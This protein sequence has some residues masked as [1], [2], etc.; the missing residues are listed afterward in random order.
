MGVFIIGPIVVAQY[1]A[2]PPQS[3][4]IHVESFRY[5]KSPAVIYCTRGD[6]LHLTFSSRDTGHSFFLQEFDMDVKVNPN[7]TRVMQFRASDPSAIPETKHEVV[8]IAEHPGLL[9]YLVSK[10]NFRCHVWCGPLHAFEQ[11]SLIIGP[12]NLLL[13][14]LGL[15]LGIFIIGTNRRRRHE[16][17]AADDD[18]T[19]N[20]T[21]FDIFERFPWIKRLM[22][23]RGFQPLLMAF[24]AV[25]MYIV[26]LTSI[27]GTQMSGRNL[28]VMLIWVVWLVLLVIIFTPMGGRAWCTICPIPMAG[29]FLQRQSIMG[30]NT[31]GK[32]KY[33]NRFMGLNLA[34]PDRFKNGWMRL[35]FFLLT[36]TMSTTFVAKPDTTGFAVLT[37]F[38]MSTVMAMIW[39]NRSFCQ[40][41]CP[42]NSFI[43]LYSQSGKVAL[44]AADLGVCAKCNGD[45]CELGSK[46]G[47]ACPYELN[48]A[49]IDENYDCGLC[50]ECIKSCLY[51]NVTLKWQ[52]LGSH[53]MVQ[54]ASRAWTAMTLF[55][56][57]TAYTIVY[58]GPWPIVREY[59]N[60]LDKGNW[61]LFGVYTALLWT[62]SLV[63]FPLAMYMITKLSKYLAVRSEST[64]DLMLGS[65]GALIPFGLF[66]WIAF[67][68]QMLFTNVS[69][70]GQSLSDPFGWGWNLLGLR[71]AVW[72]QFM[73]R[74]VPWLQVLAVLAGFTYGT[75][76]LW[77]IW[78]TTTG[79]AKIALR[80]FVPQALFFMGLAASFIWFYAN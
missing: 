5:G 46:G 45:Y 28:G 62:T 75:R 20:D 71:G 24:G 44:R 63:F 33:R 12:N 54:D 67:T 31:Q 74:T 1:T 36:A 17:C 61:D 78:L 8:L 52:R 18:P 40:Y 21:I 49:E 25:V 16:Y 29:E 65:S 38:L 73:P 43:S 59:I 57:A 34:W 35:I 55:V 32:G 58:L 53:T 69:F 48:V 11:G 2:P 3:R 79:D 68:I 26:V 76:N 23:R 15:L 19:A 80:A 51:D 66:I 56:I 50:T 22:K 60:I 72:V 39:S 9:K 7:T 14:G 41:L 64:F 10:S 42:I 30:V 13:A 4:T 47:W 37:L 27:F 77:R 70:V 6:T